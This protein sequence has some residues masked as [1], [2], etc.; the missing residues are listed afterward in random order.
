MLL[1]KG[2]TECQDPLSL[3]LTFPLLFFVQ[4]RELSQSLTPSLSLCIRLSLNIPPSLSPLSLSHLPP[5]LT[6]TSLSLSLSLSH[7]H[8]LT[9]LSISVFSIYLGIPPSF[10]LSL[11]PSLYLFFSQYLGIP[12]SIYL[13]LFLS[14]SL[15]HSLTIHISLFFPLSIYCSHYL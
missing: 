1:K 9:S 15:S 3:S 10:P 13:S 2:G 5:S 12:P 8:T 14:L 11:T 6:L 4:S 7:T